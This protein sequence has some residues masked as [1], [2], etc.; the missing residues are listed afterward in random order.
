[1]KIT[2]ALLA[3]VLVDSAYSW[4]GRFNRFSPEMLSNLG[5]GAG[6]GYG[7]NRH[8]AQ[9]IWSNSYFSS[10]KML[11][12]W[13]INQ[14]D[15]YNVRWFCVGSREEKVLGSYVPHLV[16]TTL[17]TLTLLFDL[18]R[19]DAACVSRWVAT[20]SHT[21]MA[22]MMA[23]LVWFNSWFLVRG[24]EKSSFCSRSNRGRIDGGD[25]HWN[26]WPELGVDDISM[27]AVE[28]LATKYTYFWVSLG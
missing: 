7:N 23:F 19:I 8:A 25:C 3:L 22:L 4:G 10:Y 18:R 27:T 24:K 1:M 21:L 28:H 14:R 11:V 17:T 6:Y 15:L 2:L 26:R 16:L 13:W 12:W 9:V 5:Y 20:V